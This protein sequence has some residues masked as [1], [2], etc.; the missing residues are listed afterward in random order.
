MAHAISLARNSSDASG[1]AALE[2]VLGFSADENLL[3]NSRKIVGNLTAKHGEMV[4]AWVR[5]LEPGEHRDEC[6]SSIAMDIGIRLKK[7]EAWMEWVDRIESESIRERTLADID[8]FR[9]PNRTSNQ[10]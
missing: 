9:A 7:G 5:D 6:V 3:D 4:Q 2:R 10:K 1:L 8:K